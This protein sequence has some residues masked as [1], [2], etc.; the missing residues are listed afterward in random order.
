MTLFD[1][2]YYSA[3]AWYIA[4]VVTSSAGPFNVFVWIREHLPLGGLTSC[5]ICLMIWTA[6]A[7]RLIGHNIVTDALAVAGVALWLH[8][9]T[10]WRIKM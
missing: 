8:S 7:L 5:I 2:L 9:F 6:L 1:V 10:G 4:Y 3:A